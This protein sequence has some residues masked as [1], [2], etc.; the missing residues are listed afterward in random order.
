MDSLQ[1]KQRFLSEIRT[2]FRHGALNTS[3]NER[4]LSDFHNFLERN[5]PYD[6]PGRVKKGANCVGR[7]VRS[8]VRV[9]WIPSPSLKIWLSNYDIV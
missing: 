1:C 8:S 3:F 7:Q 6:E 5:F 2:T 4:E 9:L